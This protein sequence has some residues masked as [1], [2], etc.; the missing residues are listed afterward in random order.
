MS[1]Q[2]DKLPTIANVFLFSVLVAGA[3]LLSSFAFAS[4]LCFQVAALPDALK[5]TCPAAAFL[6]VSMWVS[7]IS[8][9]VAI[10]CLTWEHLQKGKQ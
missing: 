5:Q 8:L 2:K 4:V 3:F 7:G 9:A 1:K 6:T 10:G